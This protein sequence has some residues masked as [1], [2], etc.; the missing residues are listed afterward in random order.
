LREYAEKYRTHMYKI[1][2]IY[3]NDLKSEGRHISNS[4]VIDYVNKVHPTLQM[5]ALNYDMRKRQV[6]ILQVD[7]ETETETSL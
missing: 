2:Q 7:A 1:H 6:D 4:V 3:V 5:Y